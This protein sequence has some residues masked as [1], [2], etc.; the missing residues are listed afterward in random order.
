MGLQVH[1][2]PNLL[3]TAVPLAPSAALCNMT[4]CLQ[5]QTEWISDAIAHVR[6]RGASTIEPMKDTEDA[7]VA[8]HEELA[9]ATLVMN[10]TGWYLGSNVPGKPRRLL[11][12]IGGV[13]TYRKKCD[14]VAREGYP[15]FVIQ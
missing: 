8:H 6:E 3:T 12:Y 15:G 14:E 2:Y 7:W 11:S 10:T 9:G 13:G 1:G 5:Q 4:T